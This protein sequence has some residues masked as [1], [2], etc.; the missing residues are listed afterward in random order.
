MQNRRRN[1]KQRNNVCEEQPSHMLG[2]QSPLSKFARYEPNKLS[3]PVH[4]S[5]DTIVPLRA[6]CRQISD[7]IHAVVLE[8]RGR[9]GE[10]LQQTRCSLCPILCSLTNLALF[11][12]GGDVPL[13]VWPPHSL[14]QGVQHLCCPKMPCKCTVVCLIK[15]QLSGSL[16]DHR[17][18]QTPRLVPK[19]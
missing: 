19:K 14:L 9:Y 2:I 10:W 13:H 1:P 8:S 12:M 4:N 15:Q 7:E 5:E 18:G 6:T 3:E 17:L 16:G 11:D